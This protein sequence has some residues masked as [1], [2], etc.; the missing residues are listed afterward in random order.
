MTGGSYPQGITGTAAH[1]ASPLVPVTPEPGDYAAPVE[2]T[3]QLPSSAQQARALPPDQ[4]LVHCQPVLVP[5]RPGGT[6]ATRSTL[7]VLCKRR[8]R[9]HCK[10]EADPGEERAAGKQRSPGER[11]VWLQMKGFFFFERDF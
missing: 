7:P 10:L 2:Y 1:I 8:F 3:K 4:L 6:G 5:G 9:S 11:H